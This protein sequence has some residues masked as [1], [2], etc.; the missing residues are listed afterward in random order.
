MIAKYRARVAALNE[1]I[2]RLRGAGGT[3]E[4]VQLEVPHQGA[5]P[6]ASAVGVSRGDV[7]MTE[8]LTEPPAASGTGGASST[9]AGTAAAVPAETASGQGGGGGGAGG[10]GGGSIGAHVGNTEPAAD[11]S[12]EDKP[13]GGLWL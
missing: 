12:G 13:A 8:A 1:E 5:C 10:G 2:A 4:A 9:A 7:Q 3:L 11:G 6:Q